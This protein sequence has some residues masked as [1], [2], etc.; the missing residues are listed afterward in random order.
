[1]NKHF[2]KEV[3]SIHGGNTCKLVELW[4]D[5]IRIHGNYLHLPDLNDVDLNDLIHALDMLSRH[6]D[7]E[8]EILTLQRDLADAAVIELE[9]AYNK[10]DVEFGGLAHDSWKQN[11]DA[12]KKMSKKNT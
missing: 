8:I 7:D 1:M 4:S 9:A 10:A 11:Y 6:R 3:T 12:R 2:D 5:G